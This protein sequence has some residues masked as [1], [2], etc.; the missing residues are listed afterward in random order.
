MLVWFSI[1][2]CSACRAQKLFCSSSSKLSKKHNTGLCFE[3]FLLAFLIAFYLHV[4]MVFF[5]VFAINPIWPKL[6]K[7][8]APQNLT[9]FDNVELNDLGSYTLGNIIAC[10][11]NLLASDDSIFPN[12]NDN[13]CFFN[14]KQEQQW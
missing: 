12:R 4:L 10:L 7:I 3:V 1:S 9:F 6:V 14:W 11:L 2:G 13:V 5:I 8:Q